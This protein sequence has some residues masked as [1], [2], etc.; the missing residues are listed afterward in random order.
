MATATDLDTSAALAKLITASG[1]YNN[2]LVDT[3]RDLYDAN[4][5]WANATDLDSDGSEDQHEMAE[6]LAD[7]ADDVIKAGI[8]AATA[9][10]ELTRFIQQIANLALDG[11]PTDIIHS[12]INQA[13]DLLNRAGMTGA[14]A[15]PAPRTSRRGPTG[16]AVG[17]HGSPSPDPATTP[18]P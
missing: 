12:L 13:R 11:E 2:R 17:T 8:L 10:V 18:T 7:T 16:T 9:T 15:D 3:L 1:G 14:A 5:T 6:T 4:Q